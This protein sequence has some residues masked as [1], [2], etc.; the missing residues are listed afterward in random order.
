MATERSTDAP[1]MVRVCPKCGYPV[2]GIDATCP[3]YP[4]GRIGGLC[5]DDLSDNSDHRVIYGVGHF[6][7]VD[8][9]EAVISALRDVLAAVREGE[10][11]RW[12]ERR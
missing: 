2:S 7:Q 6:I 11:V 1:R 4:W 3:N 10:R 12:D 5:G 8:E 9:P